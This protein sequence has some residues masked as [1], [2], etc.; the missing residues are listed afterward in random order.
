MEIYGNWVTVYI[1]SRDNGEYKGY[2]LDT[3]VAEGL[4]LATYKI[5]LHNN[6]FIDYLKITLPLPGLLTLKDCKTI[7]W[8]TMSEL[9]MALVQK[10]SQNSML[11]VKKVIFTPFPSKVL[12][13]RSII[14]EE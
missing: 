3:N 5:L 6:T 4:L 14:G 10:S 1:V 7:D 11:Q 13:M 8:K 9:T 2:L 12:A